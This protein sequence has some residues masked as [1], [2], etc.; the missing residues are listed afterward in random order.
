VPRIADLELRR[1]YANGDTTRTSGDVIARE[2]TLMP[3]VEVALARERQ[4]VGGDDAAGANG[5]E[6]VTDL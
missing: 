3:F 4:W 1:V 6:R 5:G 2:R